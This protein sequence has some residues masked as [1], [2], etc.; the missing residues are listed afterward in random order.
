MNLLRN[1]LPS[2]IEFSENEAGQLGSISPDRYTVEVRPPWNTDVPTSLE[3]V[4]Q[5]IWEMQTK[6]FKLWNISPVVSFEI[7]RFHRDQ[8]RLQFTVPT[9][10]LER[11]LRTGL[12]TAIPEIGFNEDRD[13][14]GLPVS[15]GASVGGGMLKLGRMDYYPLN[16]DHDNPPSNDVVSSLHRDAMQDTRFLIQ[17]LFKPVAGRSLGTWWQRKSAYRRRNYLRKNKESLTNSRSATPREKK[18]ANKIEDKA[19]GPLYH[20]GIRFFVVG[21]GEHTPSRVKELASGYNRFESSLTGQYLDTV[22][23]RS[24]RRK[25]F[26]RFARSVAERRFDGWNMKFRLSLPEIA[27]VVSLPSIEQNNISYSQ[28]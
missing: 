24:I 6:W 9:K 14:S 15:E 2:Y 3:S 7:C 25:S 13:S 10:R 17:V 23:L 11:N 1:R 4:L 26:T 20:T 27:A 22:T 18:Q 28:P 5:N 16:T 19:G 8:V 12:K 21:A